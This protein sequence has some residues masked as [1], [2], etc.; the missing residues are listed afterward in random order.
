MDLW[1]KQKEGFARMHGEHHPERMRPGPYES[2]TL[3]YS[4]HFHSKCLAPTAL[5]YSLL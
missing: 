4:R 3:C 1:Q 2:K 5:L